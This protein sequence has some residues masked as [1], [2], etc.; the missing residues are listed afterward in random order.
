MT[1]YAVHF[2]CDECSQVH[3]LGIAINLNDGPASKT[4]LSDTYDGKELPP[5]IATLIN[6]STMCPV[7]KKMTSQ[8]NNNQVFLVPVSN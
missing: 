2:F 7:T 8:K 1:K 6:N 5:Q 3:P 4:S